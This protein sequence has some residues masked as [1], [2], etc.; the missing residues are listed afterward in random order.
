MTVIATKNDKE[1]LSGL[2]MDDVAGLVHDYNYAHG[3]TLTEASETTVEIGQI[4]VWET[5]HWEV[6]Q[7]LDTLTGDG[8]AETGGYGL[9]VVVGF[10]ALGDQYSKA[11]T[12]GNIVVL[13]QGMVNI[14]ES[15]LKYGTLD[16]AE[17][18]AAKVQLAKQGLKL[19][20]TANSLGTSFYSS[21][22]SA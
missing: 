1:V 15:G 17:Q 21:S 12:S 6:V 18:T 5:D 4:V 16:S 20:T 2:V 13:Y 11:I 7:N 14:K 10:D 22:L 19:K 9:A 3:Q 8:A